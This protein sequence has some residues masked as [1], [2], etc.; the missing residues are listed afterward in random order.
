M[1]NKTFKEATSD[2]TSEEIET[3]E[4]MEVGQSGEQP[5]FLNSFIE[6]LKILNLYLVERGWTDNKSFID[7]GYGYITFSTEKAL[8]ENDSK[9]FK[10]LSTELKVKINIDKTKPKNQAVTSYNIKVE[11]IIEYEDYLEIY[12]QIQIK[13]EQK[14]QMKLEGGMV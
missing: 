1:E 12:N 8:N 10:Q 4:E 7:D 2:T 6:K 13:K 5:L 3:E 9:I 14:E 11:N